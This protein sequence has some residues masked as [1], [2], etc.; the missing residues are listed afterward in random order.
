MLVH[1]VYGT[2][3]NTFR[4]LVKMFW[5]YLRKMYTMDELNPELYTSQED[6]QFMQQQVHELISEISMKKYGL[7]VFYVPY[8]VNSCTP[9]Y[10][11]GT[12]T[13]PFDPSSM[14]RL[15]KMPKYPRILRTQFEVQ[16]NNIHMY[17]ISEDN[18]LNAK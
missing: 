4:D 6:A 18:E 15:E 5:W 10:V 13:E 3:V 14:L 7:G 11:I 17:M 9:E 2:K 8:I 12:Y 1:V 16:P